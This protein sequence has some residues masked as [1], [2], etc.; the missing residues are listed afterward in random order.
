[1]EFLHFKLGIFIFHFAHLSNAIIAKES[2]L[3]LIATLKSKI[4]EFKEK[5]GLAKDEHLKFVVMLRK[6]TRILV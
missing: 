1:M 6:N 3:A 2:S 4:S 5:S